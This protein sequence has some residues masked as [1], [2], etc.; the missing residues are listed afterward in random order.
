MPRSV[1]RNGNA[2]CEWCR[3]QL[4]VT[5]RYAAKESSRPV[6]GCHPRCA[7]E[8]AAAVVTPGAPQ[9]CPEIAE[10]LG[11]SRH[12][13]EQILYTALTKVCAASD[14]AE[15]CKTCRATGYFASKI[16]PD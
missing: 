5:P 8:R 12:R 10:R 14:G 4:P 16:C 15:V 1:P 9:S 3:M 11:L 2:A 13:V 7:R 6:D